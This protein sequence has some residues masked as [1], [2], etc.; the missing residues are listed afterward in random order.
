MK[1]LCITDPLTHPADDT[2]VRLYERLP[3][4]RRFEMYHLEAS[5]VGPADEIPVLR[6]SSPVSFQAFRALADEPTDSARYTDFD[7]V[8]SRADK[9]YPPAFLPGLTR[10]EG[11]TRF[12]ARP[13]SVQACD[14]RAFYRTHLEQF[15]PP[16]LM[17]RD[18][19][20]AIAFIT[21]MGHVVAKSNRSYGGKG[22]SRI[23]RQGDR[24]SIQHGTGDDSI[25]RGSIEE[26]LE[27][28]FSRDPEEY[29]L[30][31]FLPNVT[32]G[33]KRIL[34]VDGEIYGGFLRLASDGGWINNLTR[35]GTMH[36][37][38]VTPGEVRVI[39]ATCG[40]YHEQG[41]HTLGY[42]FLMGESGAW[43]LSEVNASGNIGGYHQLERT[44]GKPVL[45]RLFDWLLEFATR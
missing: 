37:A 30:V 38:S 23:W 12:V 20:E 15:L 32:A 8:F 33:D 18:V 11:R 9:P 45:P 6:I 31:R 35:G 44:S 13:S 22:V 39:E 43:V 7:L 28:L 42:D 29:E 14:H 17:T 24:W 2:T 21:E 27:V 1:L 3:E 10:Q 19:A 36:A 4:D 40:L 5:R 25:Q 41:L 34:V 16:G 26:L